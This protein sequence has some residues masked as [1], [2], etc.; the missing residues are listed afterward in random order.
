MPTI[1]LSFSLKEAM[2][3]IMRCHFSLR[4]T[5]MNKTHHIPCW[6]ECRKRGSIYPTDG[7]ENRY[8]SFVGHQ[9]I[10]MIFS[11]TGMLLSIHSRK[12]IGTGVPR[13]ISKILFVIDKLEIIIHQERISSITTQQAKRFSIS[14]LDD[15]ENVCTILSEK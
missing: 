6:L 2:S 4:I 13:G 1:S 12:N 10:R 14:V 9:K 11:L 5:Q 8:S 7:S 15:M 3:K